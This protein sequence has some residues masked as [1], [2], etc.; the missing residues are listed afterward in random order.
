M[1]LVLEDTLNRIE[2][3]KEKL[4]QCHALPDV[5]INKQKKKM[6]KRNMKIQEQIK[7]MTK[8]VFKVE[9]KIKYFGI[10]TTIIN[11]NKTDMNFMSF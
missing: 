11:I 4:K 3:I 6:L 5:K 10:N 2:S 9:K 1:V 7:L 8:M